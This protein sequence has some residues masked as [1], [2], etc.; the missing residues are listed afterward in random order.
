[1]I[2]ALFIMK[3]LH[4]CITYLLVFL[5]E[6]LPIYPPARLHQTN[7]VALNQTMSRDEACAMLELATAQ[8]RVHLVLRTI[9]SLEVKVVRNILLSSIECYHEL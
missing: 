8:T 3:Q 1:M 9:V 5:L 7:D 2:N 4:R 6:R